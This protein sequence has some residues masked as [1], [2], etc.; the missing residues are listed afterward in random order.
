MKKGEDRR[1]TIWRRSSA[2][3]ANADAHLA[4]TAKLDKTNWQLASSGR[5]AVVALTALDLKTMYELQ[6][7]SNYRRFL[8]TRVALRFFLADFFL[9]LRAF[10]SAAFLTLK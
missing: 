1:A 7:I 6:F 9:S 3:G 10:W 4:F 8:E 5:A 2:V